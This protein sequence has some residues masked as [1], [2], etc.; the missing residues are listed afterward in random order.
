MLPECCR[1]SCIPTGR[2]MVLLPATAT[3][4]S[5]LGEARRLLSDWLL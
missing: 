1:R 2:E 5:A 3:L 4:E